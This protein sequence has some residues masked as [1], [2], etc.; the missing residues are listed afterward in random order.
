MN[1]DGTPDLVAVVI[2]Q[3]KL[4]GYVK[5]SDL[6]CASGLDVV[7]SPAEAL[8]WDKASKDRNISVPVYKSD[9][10]TVIGTFV[11]DHAARPSAPTVPLSSLSLG[12]QS[13]G[14]P[15]PPASGP[16]PPSTI[17]PAAVTTVQAP[18][19]TSGQ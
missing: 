12:C 7:H 1:Q 8:A 17:A 11:A 19:A 16:Q 13:P 15:G 18:A 9:G 14:S 6:N 3:G 4:Q 2:E 10:T 5:A